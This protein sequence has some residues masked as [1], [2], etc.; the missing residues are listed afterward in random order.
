MVDVSALFAVMLVLLFSRTHGG[1]RKIAITTAIA[2]ACI[3]QLKAY[4]LRN[5]ILDST[6]TYRGHYFHH[7]FTLMHTDAYP[8]NPAN[9]I[10][11]EEHTEDFSAQDAPY[12]RDTMGSRCMMMDA[13]V[14]YAGDATYRLPD[15]FRRPGH[16]RIRVAF[17]YLL[18]EPHDNTHL[19]VA[20]MRGDSVI[21]YHPFY[22]NRTTPA[23]RWHQKA[24]G[25]E[26]D[27]A[28]GDAVKVYFWNPDRKPSAFIDNVTTGFYLSNGN[29]EITD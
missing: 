22:I 5:G 18:K 26:L 10:R 17:D 16:A 11:S 15:F 1:S 9:I 29:D 24:F 19:V 27:G 21:S 28:E 25:F 14:E 3:F 12:V 23:D 4:Q 20:I 13:G 7:F 8:I 2:C 6:Y